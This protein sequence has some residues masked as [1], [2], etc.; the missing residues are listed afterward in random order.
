MKRRCLFVIA[1]LL[2]ISLSACN[3]PI[4]AGHSGAISQTEIALNVA[5][6]QFAASQTA[7]VPP[8][9]EPTATVAIPTA[10]PE[11]LSPP[12]T[13]EPAFTPTRGG[14]WLTVQENTNC[15][16]GPGSLFDF[17]GL[18]NAGQQVEAV[19]RSTVGEYYYIK[20]PT[21]YSD[22][23]WLWSRYTTIA[24]DTGT[25]PVFTPQP[26]PTP[27]VTP[28]FTKAPADFFVKY[29]NTQT[30]SGLYG[31]Q[32]Y[33][34]NTGST[35]WQSIRVRLDDNTSAVTTNHKNNYFFGTDGCVKDL[36]NRQGDLTPG[37]YSR[38]ALVD[39][40]ELSYNPSGHSFTAQVTLY[41]GDDQTG[42]SVTKTITFTP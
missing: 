30:C 3:L 32:L 20:N 33:I 21:S 41:S 40:G 31:I 18:I 9:A 22:Y 36:S 6:T 23:C 12:N 27:K 35:T 19:A 8:T 39:D 14:V 17:M 38:V 13:P 16:S 29:L 15:R 28:T 42:V 11:V 2:S 37:E 10:A 25:L 7:A 24:G 34:E 5:L 4:N 1:L 26:S